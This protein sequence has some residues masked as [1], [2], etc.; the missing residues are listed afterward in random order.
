MFCDIKTHFFIEL[1]QGTIGNYAWNHRSPIK[2]PMVSYIVTIG[3]LNSDSI[4]NTC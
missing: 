2:K 3:F 1:T 4:N